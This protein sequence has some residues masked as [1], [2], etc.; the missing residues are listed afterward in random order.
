MAL[1]EVRLEEASDTELLEWVRVGDERGVEALVHRY[2][3]L[4]YRLA[5]RLTGS[6]EDA[7]EVTWEVMQTVWRKVSGF[8]GDSALFSWIYRVAANAAYMKLRARPPSAIPLGNALETLAE[9]D[10]R[11]GTP[12]D[13]SELCEDP[14]VQTEL[15]AVLEDGIVELPP[16]Y[17]TAVVLRD[18]EGLSNEEAAEILGLTI[19]AVK[20][21]VHRTRL[22]LRGRLDRYFADA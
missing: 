10:T 1:T 8:R 12:R 3:G 20:T 4:V 21:L 13:W 14:A 22:A 17:R 7:E 18:V 2:A 15:R 6:H 16:H 11:I 5:R 19:P 9:A